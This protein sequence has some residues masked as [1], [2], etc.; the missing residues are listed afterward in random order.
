MQPYLLIADDAMSLTARIKSYFTARGYRVHSVADG[1]ECIESMQLELP[2]VV[3]LDCELLWGG[4]DG[5][6]SW[7]Q[8]EL[9]R[10]RIPVIMMSE[11]SCHEKHH[12]S[13]A[14]QIR[15]PFDVE[16]LFQAVHSVIAGTRQSLSNGSVFKGQ[17]AIAMVD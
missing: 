10:S 8:E 15:R 16:T 5:I 12:P 13:V 11:L 7:M 6:L 4:C 2:D 9:V 14:Y 17:E 3:L 1:L